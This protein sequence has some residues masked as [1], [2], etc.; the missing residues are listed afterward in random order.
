[1]NV[2]ARAPRGSIRRGGLPCASVIVTVLLSA[3]PGDE[4]DVEASGVGSDTGMIDSSS[5][6]ETTSP[7]AG[8]TSAAGAEN[9]SGDGGDDGV[10][11]TTSDSGEDSDD[12]TELG[13]CGRVE[14][15]LVAVDDPI[16]GFLG[17]YG[18]DGTCWQE[19]TAEQCWQDCR[20]LIGAYGSACPDTP[21]CCE[22]NE[23][24]DCAYR[25][26]F[27]CVD[28]ECIDMGAASGC[29]LL[30]QFCA[31]SPPFGLMLLT[32]ICEWPDCAGVA[33][34]FAGCV[35]GEYR[36]ACAELSCLAKEGCDAV[37]GC[38]AEGAALQACL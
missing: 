5:G 26:G 18:P 4:G 31:E 34:Q 9:D 7:G 14:A 19:F 36:D 33:D 38:E 12:G 24:A 22:C 13:V 1:M 15:C 29:D 17:T 8:T 2:A 10:D 3:C 37:V 35:F 27:T 20:G 25:P 6:S 16:T 21:A 30:T 11:I 28:H 23:D 32:Q